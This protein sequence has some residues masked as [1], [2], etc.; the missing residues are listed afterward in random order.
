MVEDGQWFAEAIILGR[1][2][3]R[4]NGMKFATIN[5]GR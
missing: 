2:S 4:L 3:Y 5:V 1:R